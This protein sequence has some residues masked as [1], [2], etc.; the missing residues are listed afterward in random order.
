MPADTGRKYSLHSQS[1]NLALELCKWGQ[2]DLEDCI[3][4]DFSFCFL[5]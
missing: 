1:Q 2:L 5:V 3:I 4:E